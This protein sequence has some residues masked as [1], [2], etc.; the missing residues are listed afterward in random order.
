MRIPEEMSVVDLT[1][2]NG[3]ILHPPLCSEAA[4]IQW[5]HWPWMLFQRIPGRPRLTDKQVVLKPEL[6]IRE[7]CKVIAVEEHV[8]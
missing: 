8:H 5:G 1:I 3:R 7:S 2:R 4:D 6:V